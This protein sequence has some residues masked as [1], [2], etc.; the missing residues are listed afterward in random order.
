MILKIISQRELKRFTQCVMQCFESSISLL[1]PPDSETKRLEGILPAEFVKETY[2]PQYHRDHT[3]SL[4]H[5]REPLVQKAIWEIKYK[6][7]KKTAL[8][9][10]HVLNTYLAANPELCLYTFT[11]I[12]LSKKRQRERGYNQIELVLSE[13]KKLHA[14]VTIETEVLTK[15]KNTLPQSSLESRAERLINLNGCFAVRNPE[16][17]VGRK[18]VLI[19]DVL[20][21]GSTLHEARNVLLNNGVGRIYCIALAH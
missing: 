11:P 6:K 9:L 19:D 18:V 4:L 2:R 15:I 1:F 16:K 20:T 10:A 5:Y 14:E 7:N 13:F 12:P 17:T 8:L 21:T 3:V